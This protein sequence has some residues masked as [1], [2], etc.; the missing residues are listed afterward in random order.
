MHDPRDSDH[1]GS[2]PDQQ[3]HA[4]YRLCSAHSGHENTVAKPCERG[5]A[6]RAIPLNGD[7]VVAQMMKDEAETIAPT[8]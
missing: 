2:G 6:V 1:T 5:R 8:R 3:Y 7:A 4:G